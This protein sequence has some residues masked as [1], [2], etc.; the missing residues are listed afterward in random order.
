[1]KEIHIHRINKWLLLILHKIR[2]KWYILM[3]SSIISCDVRLLREVL[4]FQMFLN[5]VLFV[6]SQQIHAVVS[7]VVALDK[8]NFHQNIGDLF[9]KSN[10][11]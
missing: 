5:L 7:R 4:V 3:F 8:I 2:P 6:V 1:M 10:Y 9:N 11:N